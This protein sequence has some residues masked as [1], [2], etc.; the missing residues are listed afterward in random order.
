MAMI[1]LK[2]K[3]IT[4]ATTRFPQVF[5]IL[6]FALLMSTIAASACPTSED[7]ISTDRPSVA[8]SSSVVP[9]GSLQIEN[10]F[11]VSQGQG[12]TTYD[13]PET[14]LRF[15][16]GQCSELLVDLPDF[17][18]SDGRTA[19]TGVTNIGP[20]FK[21]QFSDLIERLN[22]SATLGVFLRTG[23]NAIAGAGPAPY[24]Q[25]PW[26]YDLGQSWSI[27]GMFS[28]VSHRHDF[29]AST[30]YQISTYLDR[31]VGDKADMF[32][33]YINDSQ[34]AAATLHRVDI[35]GSYRLTP[36]QQFDFKIGTGINSASPS[37]YVTVGY[38]FRFDHLF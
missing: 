26:S 21:H 15:G 12:T 9:A 6:A 30:A 4:G 27:N 1:F 20:A 11:T 10:G 38:S 14:R 31:A 23:D 35:G 16:L 22:F 2:L 24:A 3:A 18:K 34:V 29:N 28:A 7:S 13:L 19:V 33:E 8:N 25:M 17:T 5:V 32:I 37:A 36:H